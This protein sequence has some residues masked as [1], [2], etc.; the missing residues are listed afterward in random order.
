MKCFERL[1]KDHI[2]STLPATLDP[3]QFAY[4]P[5]RSTDDA[6]AI[7]LHTALS[8][9]V[10]RNTYVRMLFIDYSSVFTTIVPSKLIIKLEALGLNPTLC[11]CVLDFLTGRPQVVKEGNN[12]STSLTL[13]TGA[14]QGCV[15]SPLLYSLFT[16]GC[17]AMHASNSIIKFADD[18]TVV[19]LIT[20]NDETAYRE[21]VRT[22]G[23]WC[24]GNNLSL[25]VNKT[26]EMD[27]GL[28]ET[29]EGATTLSSS[30]GQQWSRW[31]VL[32]SS[33]Y[34]SQTN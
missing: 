19:G 8:R 23:V 17:V 25:N 20:N 10:K 15:L 30:K 3:I 7:T 11:N 1:V 5:N 14:P 27:H 4:R 28:Q 2:T 26:K 13:N 29:A 22:L 9:L 16:H 34:T 32:S 21:E 31:K 18:T 12:I 33:A 6:I 24:Q